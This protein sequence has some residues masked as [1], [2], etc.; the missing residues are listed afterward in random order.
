VE[1]EMK[2]LRQKG[3]SFE[4]YDLPGLKTVDGIAS[5][6]NEKA[7]WFKDSE[8]NILALTQRLN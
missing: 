1:K 6:G 2:E 4:N 5:M 3:V 8:D 7:A